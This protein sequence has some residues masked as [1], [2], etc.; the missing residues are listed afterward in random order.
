MIP[1]TH[2]KP[3]TWLAQVRRAI[4]WL[5]EERSDPLRYAAALILRQMAENAPAVFNVHVRSFIEV[6]WSGLR[7]GKQYVR[8]ASVEALRVN[9]SN[10]TSNPIRNRYMTECLLHPAAGLV[11]CFSMR[12]YVLTVGRFI[13]HFLKLE[14]FC[15]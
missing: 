8:E 14:Q 15:I 2:T 3:C 5:R 11:F 6:I 12:Y 7:D 10:F 9:T 1:G 4:L 13:L